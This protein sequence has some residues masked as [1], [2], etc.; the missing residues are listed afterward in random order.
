MYGAAS[1]AYD[2]RAEAEAERRR[3]AR[4]KAGVAAWAPQPNTPQERAYHCE[5]DV[6]GYGGAAGGGKSDLLLGMAGTLHQRSII[7]RR[8]F[9]S[10]RGLIERSREVFPDDDYNESL[11]VWRLG[12]GRMIEFGSV[13]YE[14]DRKKFQGQPHDFIGVDEATEFPEA[15]IRFLSAWN[16]SVVPG[17][18][19][20]MVLTFNP[21]MDDAG[22]GWYAT[23][24]PGL[25]AIMRTPQRMASCATMR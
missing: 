21:P 5:A 23:S 18:A 11:H 12:G 15:T 16:R 1:R 7:F 20:R 25:T 19:C 14:Q 10:M 4:A 8:V 6:I 13:Q 24:L 17:Q 3:R 2:P 22:E 9:P